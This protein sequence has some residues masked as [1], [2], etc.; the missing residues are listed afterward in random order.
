MF[1]H[2]TN[3]LIPFLYR[4][5]YWEEML[6]ESSVHLLF[7]FQENEEEKKQ[8]SAEAEDKQKQEVEEESASQSGLSKGEC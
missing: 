1:P 7:F 4:I 6:L 3:S 2:N 5:H 8:K